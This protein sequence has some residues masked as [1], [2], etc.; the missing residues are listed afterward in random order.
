M[1]LDNALDIYEEFLLHTREHGHFEAAK[2]DDAGNERICLKFDKGFT[3]ELT[4]KKS[5]K[6]SAVLRCWWDEG[7]VVRPRSVERL[8]REFG[9]N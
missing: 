8:L 7:E 9:K 1:N 6:D 3:V 2:C 4:N 5:A